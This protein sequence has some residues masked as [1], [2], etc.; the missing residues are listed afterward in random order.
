MTTVRVDFSGP[1][2]DGRAERAMTRALADIRRKVAIE[3]ERLAGS[4]LMA[5]VRHSR[6]G[7]AV[8]SV[9]ITDASR[10]YQTGKYTMPILCGPDE[11]VVTTSLAS[12][13]PWLEGTGSRN[14]PNTRFHGYHSFRLAGQQLDGL[15]EGIAEDALQPYIREMN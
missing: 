2:F 5:S 12:Y 10:A 14:Y 13:G 3:G 8:A 7:R 9:T 15:A 6:T 4:V 1:I 11:E